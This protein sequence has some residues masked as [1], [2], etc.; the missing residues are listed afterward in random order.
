MKVSTSPKFLFIVVIIL[1]ES[2]DSQSLNVSKKKQLKEKKEITAGS[3]VEIACNQDIL[4]SYL[5]KGRSK[6]SVTDPFL[7]CPKVTNS[8]CTKQDQQR[9]YHIVN[10]ILPARL[11]EYES[12]IKMVL[13]KMKNFHKR[14]V[15]SAPAMMGSS[16]RR[17][18][19]MRQARNVLNYPFNNL[20]TSL[21]ESIEQIGIEMKSYYQSFFCIICDGGNHPFFEFGGRSKKA[22]FDLTFCKE[23][24]SPKVSIMRNLNVDL[25]EYLRGLQNLVDCTHYVRSYDLPFFDHEKVNQSGDV[26]QCLNFINSRSFLRYCKPICEKITFSKIVIL[27]Q[28]DFEFLGDA[29]NL[30]EKFYDFKETGNFVSTKLRNFFKRF[31]IPVSASP[32]KKRALTLSKDQHNSQSLFK[33]SVKH[34]QKSIRISSGGKNF[35]NRKLIMLWEKEETQKQK[36]KSLND[37]TDS[38][39]KKERKL[40]S[41]SDSNKSDRVVSSSSSGSMLDEKTQKVN[42]NIDNSFPVSSNEQNKSQSTIDSGSETELLDQRIL[43]SENTNTAEKKTR[44]AKLAVNPLLLEFYEMIMVGQINRASTHIY[45]VQSLPIDF[46]SPLKTWSVG[47]GI[48]P[49]KYEQNHFNMTSHQFYR[50]LYNFQKREVQDVN[51]EFFLADFTKE[52]FEEFTSELKTEFE[53]DPRDFTLSIEK[54]TALNSTTQA[55]KLGSTMIP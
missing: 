12:K 53:M 50:L 7:L 32:H 35:T 43:A 54:S 24:L 29:A 41:N 31:V 2:C 10:D 55:P 28:G 4:R 46:D 9:I 36:I 1:L 25:I 17:K 6:A 26:V 27:I 34:K 14:V 8:C 47:N 19:C 37:V 52:N 18:F 20:Y 44:L 42:G 22:I 40:I 16:R 11:N 21:V 23:F 38:G 3:F 13:S 48:N 49:S 33:K 15:D 30:F 45:N 51:L 5:L 39:A